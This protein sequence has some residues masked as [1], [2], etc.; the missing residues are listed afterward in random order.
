MGKFVK[1]DVR[2]LCALTTGPLWPP[3]LLLFLHV[4]KEVPYKRCPSQRSQSEVRVP[5]LP[6]LRT[7]RAPSPRSMFS[8]SGWGGIATRFSTL[9][10]V[11]WRP[12]SLCIFRALGVMCLGMCY[13]FMIILFRA[14]NGVSTEHSRWNRSFLRTKLFVGHRRGGV[15]LHV[16][17][18]TSR[19]FFSSF[20]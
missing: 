16:L 17:Q 15:I 9:K 18:S 8:F 13:R 5:L 20:C 10:S 1:Q 11:N 7:T 2:E 4:A 6:V 14:P 12:P 3:W 19:S